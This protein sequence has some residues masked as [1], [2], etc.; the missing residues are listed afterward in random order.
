LIPLTTSVTETM[1]VKAG[2]QRFLLPM[3]DIMAVFGYHQSAIVEITGCGERFRFKDKLI[4]V[5]RLYRIFNIQGSVSDPSKAVILVIK[6]MDHTCAFIAEELL[7]QHQV[8]IKSLGDNI[9]KGGAV[10]GGAILDDGSVGIVLDAS[11]LSDVAD[12]KQ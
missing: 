6:C 2:E 7:G 3:Q 1:L 8:E 11:K 12:K 10:A 4:P 5:F 9:G